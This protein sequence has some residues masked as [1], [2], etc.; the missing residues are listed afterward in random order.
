MDK[1]CVYGKA[2]REIGKKQNKTKLYKRGKKKKKKNKYLGGGRLR[3]EKNKSK[4]VPG[5]NQ[6]LVAS[7]AG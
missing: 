2:K 4:P 5:W 3:G 6:Q 7:T 1:F